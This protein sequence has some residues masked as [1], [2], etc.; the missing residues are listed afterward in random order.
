MLLSTDASG[1]AREADRLNHLTQC[2]LDGWGSGVEVALTA[3]SFQRRVD[4]GDRQR[5]RLVWVRDPDRHITGLGGV[6][7][8]Q[9]VQPLSA[10]KS[11]AALAV[12]TCALVEV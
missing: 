8:D 12:T 7:G 11:F 2:L 5:F 9:G 3:T 1:A 10:F 6:F 4:L